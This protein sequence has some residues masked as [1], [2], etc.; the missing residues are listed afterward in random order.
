VISGAATVEQ[1]VSNVA[2]L[3]VDADSLVNLAE[4]AEDP[5]TYWQIRS[6]LR[7]T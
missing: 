4:V 6:Q 5:Q 7:W 1:L 3:D 2:A